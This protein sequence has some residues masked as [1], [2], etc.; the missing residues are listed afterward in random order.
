MASILRPLRGQKLLSPKRLHEEWSAALGCGVA[1][2]QM[3][4][5]IA[6]VTSDVEIIKCSDVSTR[7]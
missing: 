4:Q 1:D 2:T 5:S 6:P 3:T 7:T